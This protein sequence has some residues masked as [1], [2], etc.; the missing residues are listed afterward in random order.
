MSEFKGRLNNMI[1]STYKSERYIHKVRECLIDLK[2]KQYLAISVKYEPSDTC[3]IKNRKINELLAFYRSVYQSHRPYVYFV[4]LKALYPDIDKN[5][6]KT[7]IKHNP[8]RN[9]IMWYRS[10]PLP[11]RPKTIRL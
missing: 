8:V 10:P 2:K 6:F 4:C 5:K 11:S 7:A 1:E 9:Y 3:F